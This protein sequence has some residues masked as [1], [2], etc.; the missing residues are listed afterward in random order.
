MYH[1]MEFS[2]KLSRIHQICKRSEG[3]MRGLSSRKVQRY[4]ADHAYGSVVDGGGQYISGNAY[5][6][7][8]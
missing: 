5:Q 3:N 7:S 8:D 4:A 2:A 6:C 1:L